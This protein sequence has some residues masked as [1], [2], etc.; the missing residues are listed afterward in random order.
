MHRK[1]FFLWKKKIQNGKN[2]LLDL[3]RIAR[4]SNQN[5][6]LSEIYKNEGLGMGS[7]QIRNG[8]KIRNI[9]YYKLRFVGH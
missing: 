2:G 6:F 7:V 5:Q 9:H 4:P 3:S 1:D 8:T